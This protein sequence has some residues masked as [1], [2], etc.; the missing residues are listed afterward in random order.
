MTCNGKVRLNYISRNMI[1]V[2]MTSFFTYYEA[3]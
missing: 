2:Q 3:N 1:S